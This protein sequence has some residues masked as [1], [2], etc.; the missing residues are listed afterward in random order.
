MDAIR[1]QK[2]LTVIPLS[3]AILTSQEENSSPSRGFGCVAQIGMA[4]QN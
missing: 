1:E 4:N 3:S 2:E